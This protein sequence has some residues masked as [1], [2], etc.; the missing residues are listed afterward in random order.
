MCS[1]S[2][3]KASGRGGQQW[4]Y[5]LEI[6]TPTSTACQMKNGRCCITF[7]AANDHVP[8]ASVQ[9]RVSSYCKACLASI[10]V[11]SEWNN[12]LS[13]QPQ[14]EP[15]ELTAARARLA[16]SSLSQQENGQDTS[17]MPCTP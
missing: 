15:P 3:V 10:H 4:A 13:M 6:Q 2:D 1:K 8:F 11:I 5:P 7:Y 14:E 17:G 9:N 16:D 12:V